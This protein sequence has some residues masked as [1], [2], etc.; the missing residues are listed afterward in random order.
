MQSQVGYCLAKDVAA[1]HDIDAAI[2]AA[3]LDLGEYE[4]ARLLEGIAAAGTYEQLRGES[5]GKEG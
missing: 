1:L 3:G 2:T 4:Y 5:R